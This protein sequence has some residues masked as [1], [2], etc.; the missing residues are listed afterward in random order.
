MDIWNEGNT[1]KSV[2]VTCFEL[3]GDD[4]ALVRFKVVLTSSSSDF[5]R[6]ISVYAYVKIEQP[7]DVDLIPDTVNRA[8]LGLADAYAS[9]A[10]SLRR[11]AATIKRRTK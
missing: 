9:V 11:D 8:R 7:F 3:K 4:E 6:D 5:S 1:V 2:G 10:E